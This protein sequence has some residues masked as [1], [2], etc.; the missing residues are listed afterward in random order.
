MKQTSISHATIVELQLKMNF[1]DMT[2]NF[3]DIERRNATKT[4]E[5]GAL[6]FCVPKEQ[7]QH[8]LWT[9]KRMRVTDGSLVY[10][11][12]LRDTRRYV[13][14]GAFLLAT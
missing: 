2:T 4:R 12:K 10:Y 8:I 9:F 3:G 11:K 7:A 1:L 13:P 14:K 6:Y 5:R